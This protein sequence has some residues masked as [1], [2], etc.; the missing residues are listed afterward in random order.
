[1]SDFK[2]NYG[3]DLGTTN[4]SISRINKGQIEIIQKDHSF[5]FPS[6]VYIDKKNREWVGIKAYNNLG[7]KNCFR[8]FKAF[9]GTDKEYLCDVNNEAYTPDDLSSKVLLSMKNSVKDDQGF[10]AAIITIPAAFT[11]TQVQATNRAAEMAGFDYCELLQEPIAASMAYLHKN[12]NIEGKWLV[13]DL[14]GGTFDA[15]ILEMD[16]KLMSIV[17][18]GKATSGDNNLGGKLFDRSIF[19]NIIVPHLKEKYEF[20]NQLSNSDKKEKLYALMKREIEDLKKNLSDDE[21]IDFM[22]DCVIID[23][24]GERVDLDFKITRKMYEKSIKEYVD[25]AINITLDLLK[26]SKIKPEELISILPVGGP[27]L[28]PY[29]RKRIETDI[30]DKLDISIDPMT[31]VSVGAS[32]YASTRTIP[33]NK[34]KRDMS[35]IQLLIACPPQV[36]DSKVAVGIKIKD[37]GK[38]NNYS[39]NFIRNDENYETGKINFDDNA[40]IAS[41]LL[42]ENTNNQ[43][44]VELYDEKSNLCECEPNE[45]SIMQGVKLAAPPMPADTGIAVYIQDRDQEELVSIIDKGSSLPAKKTLSFKFPNDIR[46]A[47]KK[48]KC[49]VQLWGGTKNTKAIRNDFMGVLIIS[50][51]DV[52]TLIPKGSEMEITMKADESRRIEIE[53]Y[54]PYTD[55]IFKKAFDSNAV[56]ENISSDMLCNQ[57]DD[58]FNRI[59]ILMNDGN[60]SNKQKNELSDVQ[61]SLNKIKNKIKKESN[62][63]GINSEQN[64]FNGKASIV[65]NIESSLRW[66]EIEEELEQALSD[67]SLEVDRHGEYEHVEELNVLKK[68]INKIKKDKNVSA[69]KDAINQLTA[70]SIMIKGN[71]KD[72][73][74]NLITYYHAN[75]DDIP[76]KDRSEARNIID[77]IGNK[78]E[79]GEFNIDEVRVAYFNLVNLI[80]EKVQD[81]IKKKINIPTL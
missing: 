53:V 63:E 73:W 13:F 69:A 5:L 38:F 10:N 66:P 31:S 75:F 33:E 67:T 50:G 15:A 4:S 2:I 78:I 49:E 7:E 30:A 52:K 74:V 58:E 26:K 45:L 9:M 12:K 3:I 62:D 22:P 48:D 40:T 41:L 68:Q 14:G 21:S 39:I 35:K 18:N 56:D 20:D 54:V 32:Y 19:E 70:L 47:N 46:P 24:N 65:D 71:N 60:L 11:Q 28:T 36:T 51:I 8:E 44:K 72:F 6:C 80:P 81:E 37:K 61:D 27:T 23:D 16:D 64:N 55:E 57:I 34:Q 59:N 42:N 77:E 1:M 43:F 79:S 25:R 17:N 29:I 76:W